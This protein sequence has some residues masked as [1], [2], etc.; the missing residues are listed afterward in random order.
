M[1]T[2][3]LEKLPSV[4]WTQG[5]SQTIGAAEG[6]ILVN[7]N[8]HISMYSRNLLELETLE[9]SIRRKLRNVVDSMTTAVDQEPPVDKVYH[10]LFTVTLGI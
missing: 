1:Y 6:S 4:V 7:Q 9:R 5:E 10:R 2:N 3:D 8:F